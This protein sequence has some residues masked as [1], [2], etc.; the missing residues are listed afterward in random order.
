[1][2]LKSIRLF[3]RVGVLVQAW[4]A[5]CLPVWLVNSPEMCSSVFFLSTPAGCLRIRHSQ[6]AAEQLCKHAAK[7]KHMQGEK[8]MLCIFYKYYYD[9]DDY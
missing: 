3:G 5:V 8:W 7:G 9:D 1:M 6:L 4:Q 2:C